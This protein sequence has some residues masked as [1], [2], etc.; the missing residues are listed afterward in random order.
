MA[1]SARPLPAPSRRHWC[2]RP[3][4][5]CHRAARASVLASCSP[6]RARVEA[7]LVA[8]RVDVA[9][10]QA[11]AQRLRGVIAELVARVVA[12]GIAA[13]PLPLQAG[14]GVE[15]AALAQRHHMAQHGVAPNSSNDCGSWCCRRCR[16]YSCRACVRCAARPRHTCR[17]GTSSAP[18]CP[19]RRCRRGPCPRPTGRRRSLA[20]IAGAPGLDQR[21]HHVVASGGGAAQG[22]AEHGVGAVQL[23]VLVGVAGVAQVRT[24]EQAAPLGAA[25]VGGRQHAAAVGQRADAGADRAG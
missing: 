19:R 22:V 7:R 16:R 5:P 14:I 20:A 4:R 25:Q 21:R 13:Q 11:R 17:P 3:A 15:L 24:E 12:H 18:G 9:R 23:E 10:A 2:P 8:G 1:P 6:G